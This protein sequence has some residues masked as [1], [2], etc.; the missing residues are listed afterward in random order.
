M[1]DSEHYETDKSRVFGNL[2]SLRFL[3]RRADDIIWGR[4]YVDSTDLNLRVF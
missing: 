1:R 4:I 2:I 3:D